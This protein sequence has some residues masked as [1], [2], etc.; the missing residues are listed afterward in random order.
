[1]NPIRHATQTIRRKEMKRRLFTMIE[2]L[3]VIA[4]ITILASML[5]PALNRARATA[6]KSSCAGNLKQ[7]GAA[8][9]LYAGDYDCFPPAKQAGFDLPNLNTW[10][11]LTMPY[12]GMSNSSP[13]DW[14]T[15]CARRESGALRC[16]ALPFDLNMRDR[17]SYAMFGFGPLAV[18]YGLTP[19][20]LV[21]GS[22]GSATA[23]YLSRPGST[24]TK[25]ADSSGIIPRPSI[26]TFVSEPCYVSGTNAS[27]ALFQDCK[28]LAN[29]AQYV[30]D[31]QNGSSGYEMAYRHAARKNVLWLDGHVSDVGFNQLHN[32]GFLK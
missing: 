7:I 14:N 30:V 23:V 24:A 2:L 4:I 6:I 20:K 16:P 29:E 19:N 5:L 10:H 15:A 28:Q 32:S 25:V 31:A 26:I 3:V 18:W 11:R 21:Y 22:A 1:M 9:Y 8:L 27:D 17:H 13:G 12:L